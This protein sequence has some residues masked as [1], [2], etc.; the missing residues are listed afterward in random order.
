[1][2]PRW[3]KRNDDDEQDVLSALLRDSLQKDEA[4]AAKQRRLLEMLGATKQT[5]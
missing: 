2:L 1:V 4:L 5:P 3:P